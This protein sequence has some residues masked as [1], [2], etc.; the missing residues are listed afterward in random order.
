MRVIPIVNAVL[1]ASVLYLLVFERGRLLEFAGITGGDT[2]T[3][4]ATVLAAP[5]EPS[6]A[7]V[8]VI[9]QRSQARELD[10]GVMVRGQTEAARRVEVRAETS[11][12]VISE[13]LRRGALVSEGALLCEI[14]PGTR[15]ASLS[16]KQARLTEAQLSATAA[17][18]LQ[19]GGFRSETS[20][21]GAMAAL[22]A[23]E[24]AVKVAEAEIGKLTIRAPFA[25]LLEDDAAEMGSLL[26]VG[27]LCAR[28]IALDPIKLVGFVAETEVDRIEQG[29]LAGGRLSNGKTLIG[30]VTFLSRAADPNTRTFRV[31]VEVA[32]SDLSVREGQTVEMLISAAS[33]PAHLLPASALTLNNE[34]HLGLRLVQDGRAAFHRVE[35]LRD[36]VDGVWL[37]GLPEIAEVIVVG[38]E[39]V[40]EGTQ[41]NVHYREAAQ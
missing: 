12:R 37:A 5:I 13:P 7:N 32:N 18:R 19:E 17:T 26:S 15:L 8:S 41:L 25:G 1:V 2:E 40:T 14:D 30:N 23:A 6:T 38:Q 35:L 27:G 29:A 4:A 11:G 9:V 21:A 39:Y 28:V 10:R 33:A 20:A 36:S 22:Q 31:E 16:E 24:A 34:G 3:T